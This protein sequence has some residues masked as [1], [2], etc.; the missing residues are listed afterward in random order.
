MAHDIRERHELSGRR[1][2]II[3]RIRRKF[4]CYIVPAYH[5]D[6][7]ETLVRSGSLDECREALADALQS[8][9]CDTF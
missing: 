2:V 7:P 8:D 9:L 5:L 4:T 6:P 3:Q 1:V